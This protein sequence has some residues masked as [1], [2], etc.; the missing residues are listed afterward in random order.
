ML[1]KFKPLPEWV[2][3]ITGSLRPAFLSVLNVY[4]EVEAAECSGPLS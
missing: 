3:R 1:P 2:V 4:R